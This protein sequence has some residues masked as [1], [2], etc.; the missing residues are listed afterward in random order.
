M[1]NIS[2]NTSYISNNAFSDMYG[3]SSLRYNM[4]VSTGAH[5]K[6]MS[7]CEKSERDVQ[8]SFRI[9]SAFALSSFYA[10]WYGN[11]YML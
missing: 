2:L 6:I 9:P 8:I 4:F 10:V 1:V 5:K 7:H 11:N 3:A